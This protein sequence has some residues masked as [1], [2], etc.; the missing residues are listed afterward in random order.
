MFLLH[1]EEIRVIKESNVMLLNSIWWHNVMRSKMPVEWRNRILCFYQ[2][3]ILRVLPSATG[4]FN[5]PISYGLNKN[6]VIDRIKYK[7]NFMIYMEHPTMIPTSIISKQP[8]SIVTLS[9][10][11]LR[12]CNYLMSKFS[13][14]LTRTKY[15]QT[16]NRC[17]DDSYLMSVEL[18]CLAFT[19]LKKHVEDVFNTG[20]VYL[21]YGGSSGIYT[22]WELNLPNY[23]V[24]WKA[25]KN[26]FPYQLTITPIE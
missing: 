3:E 6:G 21:R 25:R 18:Q 15:E 1:P 4:R 11:Q 17:K 23:N 8:A 20:I 5:E 16:L 19:Y 24:V 13:N 12:E 14:V 2:S 26:G 7:D 22:S 9:S 10:G